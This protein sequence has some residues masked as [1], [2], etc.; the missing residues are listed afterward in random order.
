MSEDDDKRRQ[1]L[2]DE[3]RKQT[4]QDIQSS[5]DSF[6]KNVLA[7]SSTVLGLSVGFIKDIVHLPTALWHGVLYAS[8]ISLSACIV[9]TIIS[10]RLSVVALNKHL[11]YLREHYENRKEEYLTKKTTAGVLIDWCTWSAVIFFVGGIVC[12]IIFCIKNVR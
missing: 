12:T 10:F 3:H 1:V 6:D 9:V 7:F 4:W 8:W 2:Y 11:E 5:T